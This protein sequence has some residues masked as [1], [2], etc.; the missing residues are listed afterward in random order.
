MYSRMA[1][2]QNYDLLLEAR[3]SLHARC[4]LPADYLPIRGNKGEAL[5]RNL[6]GFQRLM[7]LRQVLPVNYSMIAEHVGSR[8]KR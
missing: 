6:P 5:V 4:F 3:P 1:A 2:C 8:T 7:L